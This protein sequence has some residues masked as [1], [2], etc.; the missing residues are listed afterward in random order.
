LL[1][2]D[3]ILQTDGMP[4]IFNK[5]VID[6]NLLNRKVASYDVRKVGTG[7]LLEVQLKGDAGKLKIRMD[8][9]PYLSQDAKSKM[10]EQAS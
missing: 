9:V 8:P 5:T 6:A 4:S 3:L 7:Q 10:I 1:L 2:K